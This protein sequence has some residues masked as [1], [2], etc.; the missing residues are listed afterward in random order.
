MFNT[1]KNCEV[2]AHFLFPFETFVHFCSV[3]KFASKYEILAEV[4]GYRHAS[5]TGLKTAKL[6]HWSENA[7]SVEHIT[8][9]SCFRYLQLLDDNDQEKK[10]AILNILISDVLKFQ[11]SGFEKMIIFSPYPVKEKAEEKERLRLEEEKKKNEPLKLEDQDFI[12]DQDIEDIIRDKDTFNKLLNSV[13]AKGVNASKKI[14]T[15]DILSSIPDIVK[16]NLNLLTLLKETSDKF[17]NDNKDLVPFKRVVAAVFEDIVAQNPDK[18]YTELMNL[19]APEARKRLD[20]HKQVMRK[21]K[22]EKGGEK[23]GGGPRL[24]EAKSNL[25][26]S[27]QKSNPTSLESEISE[28]NK[29]LGR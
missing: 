1:V 18:K 20:L 27:L 4:E 11:S 8:G 13:Y 12:G 7:I 19:V 25:K 3:T 21:E 6:L 22:N 26:H 29:L 24:P 16:H 2:E 5:K 9:I 23:K 17:Y 10:K 14:S 15:E 28:M